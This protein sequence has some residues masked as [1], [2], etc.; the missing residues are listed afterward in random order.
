MLRRFCGAFKS[1]YF[2]CHASANALGV[3]QTNCTRAPYDFHVDLERKAIYEGVFATHDRHVYASVR[4][5]ASSC[6][7]AYAYS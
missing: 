3:C 5:C 7:G 2:I 6:I 4:D 1:C